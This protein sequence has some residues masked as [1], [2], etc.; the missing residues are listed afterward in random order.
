MRNAIVDNIRALCM[1]GVIGIHTGSLALAPNDFTLYC[2]LEILSRYS[3]P[4]FFFISGYGLC[5]TDKNLLNG[6]ALPYA[7]FMQ[8]RLRGAGLPYLSWSLLY[9]LY[10]WLI[11]P[12]GF[13]NWQPL[14]VAFVLFFGLG[15]YHLYFMVIL[16]W[17]YATY[18]LW[19]ALLRGV[20]KHSAAAGL[21]LL[22]LFQLA[23]NWWTTHPGV[24][25][26]QWSPLAKNF[27]VYRLNY[28]PLHYLLIFMGGALA[29]VYWDK[30]IAWLRA[31]P[32]TVFTLYLASVVYDAG[33]A[34]YAFRYQGY[35]LI[36]LAN[37]YH[38]LSPQGL[39]YTIASLLCF[40][41]MLD[42]L[43]RRV[44][45]GSA[46]KA[47]VYLQR[48]IELLAANSMLIYFIH[49]LLLDWLT[50]FYNKFGIVMTV[51]KVCLSYVLLVAGSLLASLL[52]QK[53]FQRSQTL[54]LLFTGKR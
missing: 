31:Y 30:F 27:F 16:L 7:D 14:H 1:L 20:I 4:A 8:K 46:G 2:L 6:G 26:S 41:L 40:C 22:L 48:G 47:A 43:E 19:R 11:L 49:P 32:L 5:C 17:F 9:M 3:V 25:P 34:Y 29:A 13:V 33:S 52:L 18:P 23:F 54:S 36:D 28:L 21:A 38:Q 53:I 24:D 12:P 42:W 15:C 51:K 37:T 10:F 39:L 35:T 44:Q 50:S 45:S